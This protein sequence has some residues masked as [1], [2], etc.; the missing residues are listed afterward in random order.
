M[1]RNEKE[2]RD[3]QNII[4]HMKNDPNGL[5][6]LKKQV[7]ENGLE[8]KVKDFERQYGKKI[9]EFI[10]ALNEKGEMTDEQK[11]R[12]MIEMKRKLPKET[13]TQF[14]AILRSM[15]EYLGNR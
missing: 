4:D 11:A 7:K 5:D 9:N 2:I 6:E 12:M 14:S 8:G 1:N 10:T 15:K 3:I 13:Q